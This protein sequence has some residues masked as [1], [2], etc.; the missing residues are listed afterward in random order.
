MRVFNRAHL[1]PEAIADITTEISAQESLSD[2]M[3]SALCSSRG[4]FIPYIEE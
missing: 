3:A 2:V 4:A 1:S